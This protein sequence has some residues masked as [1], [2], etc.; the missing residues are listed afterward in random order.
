MIVH[1]SLGVF[2]TVVCCGEAE[3]E[4]RHYIVHASQWLECMHLL[5][6]HPVDLAKKNVT[7]FLGTLLGSGSL[8]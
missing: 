8:E 5:L 3:G 4:K 7:E 1:V 6:P 2:P